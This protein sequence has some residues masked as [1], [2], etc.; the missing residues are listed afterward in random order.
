VTAPAAAVAI[1]PPPPERILVCV[2]PSPGSERLVHAARRMAE[3]LRAPWIAAY[4]DRTAAPP[5]HDDDRE[6]LEGHLRLAESL[7]AE[8]ARLRGEDVAD[9]LLAYARRHGATRL[10]AGKP[11]HARWRDRLR[12]SLLDDLICRSGSID[13]LVTAPRP[14]DQPAP[15][16]PRRRPRTGAW[17]YSLAVL[18]V[19]VTTA[20]GLATFGYIDLADIAMLYLSAIVAASVR[21]RGPAILAASLAVLSF[22]FCF[23][24]PRFTF[25]IADARHAITFAVMFGAGLVISTLMVRLRGQE[26]DA[27][28]RERHNAALLALTRD[29]R[30]ATEVVDVAVALVRHV[31]GVLDVGAAVLLPDRASGQLAPA[32]GLVPLAEPEQA[33]ARWAFEHGRRGGQGTDTMPGARVLAVPLVV[34]DSAVGVV[35]VQ[36]RPDR[37]LLDADQ[38]HLLEALVLHAAL[39]IGRST[40][41]AEAREAEL[42]ART[43]EL[44]SSLLSVVSHDLRTPLAVITGAATSLRDD[45]I[46]LTAAARAE[47]VDTLVGEA[48]RLERVVGNLLAMTR[49]ETGIEPAREWIPLEELVGAALGRVEHT[50]GDRP[51]HI[52][53]PGDL[54]VQVDPILFA[55]V[56]INL[57][58]NAVKHGEPPIE[59]VARRR[60]DRVEIDIADHGAG[61]PPGAEERVFD[62]FY[63]ASS[64]PGVGLGLAVVRGI[65]VA[66]GGTIA[67]VPSADGACFRVT[68]ADAGAPPEL[69]AEGAA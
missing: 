32:A 49:V 8:T 11:T 6:R 7:G 54:V 20:I 52:D 46:R 69:A 41:A 63:R 65:V 2:G 66:H 16:L 15:D 37:H 9:A 42:R 35:V 1:E 28:R 36:A 22:N 40:L 27:R 45:A 18:A 3:A 59:I 34:G 23:I 39:A 55:Q 24:P 26:A 29:V 31:E 21:G 14:P 67:A 60:D 43:E 61:L 47:L 57:V 25:A 19:A 50:L 48:S 13:V 33:V 38:R 5:L 30:D 17:P 44:R 64:A 56:L 53:V 4:V 51:V 68:L 62:K 12:G 58:E 10:I